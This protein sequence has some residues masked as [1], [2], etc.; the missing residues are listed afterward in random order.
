M[1]IKKDSDSFV[2]SEVEG[3]KGLP[4]V[5][6]D[7]CTACSVCSINCPT[8]A[9]EIIM[10]N[11][12]II[13]RI[14][15]GKCIACGRC[16]EVCP[17]EAIHLSKKMGQIESMKPMLIVEKSIK[18]VKCEICGTSIASELQIDK[19]KEK[20]KSVGY[21]TGKLSSI[22]VCHKCRS[23]LIKELFDKMVH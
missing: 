9:I 3:F 5:D 19:I 8:E 17:E 22:S 12:E 7:K 21:E 11:G 13:H 16:Q 4:E 20:L 1:T 10:K 18:A 23:L 2:I 14:Y 6:V 15:S